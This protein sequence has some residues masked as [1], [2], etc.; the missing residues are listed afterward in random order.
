MHGLRSRIDALRGLAG[1]LRPT[2]HQAPCRRDRF[3]AFI[4]GFE[5]EVGL[6]G[7]NIKARRIVAELAFRNAS[8]VASSVLSRHVMVN[9]PHISIALRQELP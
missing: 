7:S 5:D 1:I 4:G 8:M 6:R 2:I 9:R 3:A